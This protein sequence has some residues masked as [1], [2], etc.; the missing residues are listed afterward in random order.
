L[1]GGGNAEAEEGGGTGESSRA[2]GTSLSPPNELRGLRKKLSSLLL[3]P[4]KGKGR[5]E[6]EGGRTLGEEHLRGG[7]SGAR[8]LFR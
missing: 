1:R 7:R 3:G 2:G 8:S 5:A 4:S 6:D